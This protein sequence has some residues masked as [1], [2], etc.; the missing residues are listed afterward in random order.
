MWSSQP[1]TKTVNVRASVPNNVRA[2][3]HSTTSGNTSGRI[4]IRVDRQS[5]QM[6]YKVRYELCT[7]TN[8]YC[9]VRPMN[10][11][12][13]VADMV[14]NSSRRTFTAAG[15]TVETD[16]IL[17]DQLAMNAVY[18]VEVAAFP[19]RLPGLI[20]GYSSEPVIV[21]TSHELPEFQANGQPSRVADIPVRFYWKSGAYAPRICENSFKDGNMNAL[22][23][24]IAAVEAGVLSWKSSLN[25]LVANDK[26]LI[27]INLTKGDCPIEGETGY[28]GTSHIRL[29]TNQSEFEANCGVDNPGETTN[30]CTSILPA[31]GRTDEL[32][33]FNGAPIFFRDIARKTDW[34]AT[35]SYRS[36]ANL[37]HTSAHEAGHALGLSHTGKSY[38][39]MQSSAVT[40][41]RINNPL[42]APGPQ[43][44]AAVFGTYQSND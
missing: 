23:T 35:E 30:A 8:D 41:T 39:I 17:I 42:C 25:W 12:W 34:M 21:F 31:S 16:E 4:R 1:L 7:S 11:D 18:R 37:L 20:S 9:R 27:S 28:P 40:L 26:Q 5:I 19:V 15:Q 36:C 22:P 33:E 10:A 2:N 43:D 29:A 14:K 44:I 32:R 3:G 6:T 38:S 24:Y 13:D